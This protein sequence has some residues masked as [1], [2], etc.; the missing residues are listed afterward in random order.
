MEAAA[1]GAKDAGGVSVGLVPGKYK[2]EGN[3]ESIVRVATTLEP[4]EHSLPLI[5]SCDCLIAIGGDRETGIQIAQA[6]D[7]GLHVVIYSKAGG[8]SAEVFTNLEPT[9]QKMRSS[10]LV[11]LVENSEEAIEFA[12]KFAKNRI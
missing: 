6:V 1:K 11:Y 2:E 7:L 9:F 8:I 12:K 4:D 10:Q 5:Y 3:N